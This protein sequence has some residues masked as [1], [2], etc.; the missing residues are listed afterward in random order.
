MS[1]PVLSRQDVL[2]RILALPRPGEENILAFYEHRLGGICR[3]ARLM[4]IPLDDHLVHRSDGAFETL[5]YSRGIMYR[6]EKHL[7]RLRRSATGIGITPP[8]AWEEIVP[9]ILAVA[10]AGGEP[11]GL[12]RVLL[13]RGPGGF[14]IDPAECPV[15]GLYVAAYRHP[16]PADAWYRAGLKGTR[17]SIPAKSGGMAK[18][19]TASYLPNVLMTKEAR[20]KGADVPLSY[21]EQGFLAESAVA[22][23]LL[24][25]KEGVVL[26]PQS[27]AILP[28]TTVTRALE[29]AGS[30]LPRDKRP[31][32]EDDVR[33]AAEIL[34]LG[35]GPDCVAVTAYEGAPV[36]D[37]AEGPVC[38]ELRQLI[39]EDSLASGTPIPGLGGSGAAAPDPAW[40]A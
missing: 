18:I 15:A 28:A 39:V 2:D 23:I 1:L 33:K 29:L 21:D 7:E 37:G 10:G 14:G 19:K 5:R 30:N 4:L 40:G 32:T 22:S 6:P 8:V 26:V 35:T 38:R 25:D 11:E 24:V 27:E 17:A 36:G 13:S 16:T 12:V 20:E 3:D 34:L 9:I 31:L